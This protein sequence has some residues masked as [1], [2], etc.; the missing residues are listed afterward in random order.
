MIPFENT[1]PYELIGQDVYI[2]SCPFCAANN[3]LLTMKKKDLQTIHEGAKR[4]LVLPCCHNKVGIVDTD[5]DYLLA[6]LPLRKISLNSGG[7][8]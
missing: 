6:N 8:L 4:L 3:V 7:V 5:G 2:S 1:W